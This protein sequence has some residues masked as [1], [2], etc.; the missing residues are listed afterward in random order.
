M[1]AKRRS[2]VEKASWIAGI[3]GAGVAVVALGVTFATPG[4]QPVP[5]PVPAVSVEQ[6]AGSGSTQI[7]QVN[8]NVF[9]Q[10]PE[11]AG[12][13]SPDQ[14]SVSGE[15]PVPKIYGLSYDDAR[16]LLIQ[17]GWIPA[18]NHWT[19]G[20]GVEVQSGNGP[21]FWA[22]GYWE[23]DACAGTGA[24]HCL[25]KFFDPSRRVLLITTEGEESD[26]GE[27]HAKVT[28]YSIQGVENDG[29]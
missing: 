27:Y 5:I 8:G 25:F 22:R 14:S 18:K 13:A 17:S 21:V 4:D 28:R 19:Y 11:S 26:A 29:T 6:Q 15:F 1:S 23:L 16:K 2:N 20:Q 10:N 12:G 9:L 7:G 24:A 3:V